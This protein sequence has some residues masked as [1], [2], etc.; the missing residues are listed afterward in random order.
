M[1]QPLF[2]TL[3]IKAHQTYRRIEASVPKIG[4][5]LFVPFSAGADVSLKK[6]CLYSGEA[7]AKPPSRPRHCSTALS[8]YFF[9]SLGTA[10]KHH[11][12]M[13]NS[14]FSRLIDFLLKINKSVN[15]TP[16][17]SPATPTQTPT[18]KL[19]LKEV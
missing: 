18:K 17:K 9:F 1:L 2:Q 5:E 7:G 12:I 11:R 19:S 6:E 13:D 3:S 15:V 10:T 8:L 14:Q 16:R 4:A